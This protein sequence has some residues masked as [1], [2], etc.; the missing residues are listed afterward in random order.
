MGLGGQFHTLAT[1][2]M[3]AP[4]YSLYMRLGGGVAGLDGCG[5]EKISNMEFH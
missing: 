1:T 4:H 5:E 3:E 2:P